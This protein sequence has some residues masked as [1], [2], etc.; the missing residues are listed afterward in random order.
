MAEGG[1]KRFSP[2][3]LATALLLAVFALTWLCSGPPRLDSSRRSALPFSV[4]RALSD[5]RALSQQSGEIGSSGNA[6]R[7]RYILESLS[8]LDIPTEVQSTDAVVSL[9]GRV[10]AARVHN[11][12]A[13]LPGREHRPALLLSAHYD[14]VPNSPGAADDAAGV[15]TLLETARTLR[16]STA[17]ARDVIFLFTDGEELGLLGAEAFAGE[18]AFAHDVGW[19]LNFEARGSGGASAMY[20]TSLPNGDLIRHFSAAVPHPVGNSLI[21]SLSRLLPND[22]D[23]TV[24]RRRGIAGYAFAFA[25]GFANYHRPSDTVSELDP[26]SLAQHVSYAVAL[27]QMLSSAPS[28]RADAGNVVYFDVLGRFAISYPQWLA[29]ALALL[30]VVLVV[31]LIGGRG[32]GALRRRGLMLGVLGCV[33]AVV[34]SVLA[35]MALDA[36]LGLTLVPERRIAW[37]GWLLPAHLGLAL[38]TGV[39]IQRRLL[40]RASELE[41]LAGACVLVALIA[42]VLSIGAPGTSYAPSLSTLPVLVE[43][44]WMSRKPQMDPRNPRAVWLLGLALV[45]AAF[46]IASVSNAFYVLLGTQL[47]AA[48]MPAVAWAASFGLPFA[49]ELWR[50]RAQVVAFALVLASALIVVAASVVGQLRAKPLTYTDLTYWLDAR[51]AGGRFIASSGLDHPWLRSFLKHAQAPRVPRGTSAIRPVSESRQGSRREL[52][53]S[54]EPAGARCVSLMQLSGGHVSSVTL[55]GKAPRPNVRFS[56]ELDKKLWSLVTGQQ[57]P[58]GFSLSYCGA[59]TEPLRVELTTEAASL[60]LEIVDEYPGLPSEF[61][62][63]LPPD[64]RFEPGGNHSDLVRSVRF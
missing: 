26:R 63:R 33:I 28:E 43:L 59:S 56:P 31:V 27:T 2:R 15:A 23:F 3:S 19:V 47:P 6:A 8:R 51:S 25:D 30:L 32:G 12:V 46:F 7:R 34:F 42:A 14:T 58:G 11:V 49:A 40:R 13:R 50:P 52:V 41:L 17:L 39:E 48:T 38:A 35:A 29:R 18:H 36:L 37:A 53:L 24:F 22:T 57:L 20:E 45:P 44:L 10:V 61:E 62:P 9:L 1:R 16:G 55:N 4:E 64:L 5:V 60:E 54:I 21:S